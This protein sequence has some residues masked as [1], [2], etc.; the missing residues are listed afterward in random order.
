MAEPKRVEPAARAGEWLTALGR[1]FRQ[2]VLPGVCL[3]CHQP[4]PP[5]VADFCKECLNGFSVDSFATCPRCGSTGG[6]HLDLSQGCVRCRDRSFAFEQTIR[7][8][9]YGGLLRELI[10]R[11]KQPGGERLAEAVG[12]TWAAL[13]E[14]PLRALRPELVV[15]VALHWYRRWQRGFNQSDLLA[16]AVARRLGVRYRPRWL[17]RVR[18]T[19]KQSSLAPTERRENVRG[20]FRVSR[21][22]RLQGQSVLLIDDVLTTGSTAHEAAKALKVA[23]AGRVVVA[24]VGHG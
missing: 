4:L 19:T 11:M 13:Q 22:S 9:P 2:L 15:P 21:L 3:A 17:K 23:G 7:L 20:A 18:H 12:E 6:F 16:R 1:G 5:E 24:V 14:E 8:G 10:L